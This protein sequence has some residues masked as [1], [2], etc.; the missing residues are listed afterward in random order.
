MLRFVGLFFM[1]SLGLLPE[2]FAFCPKNFGT[3]GAAAP[4]AP[5]P[6]TPMGMKFYFALLSKKGLRL[7]NLDGINTCNFTE[8][9]RR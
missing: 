9:I 8:P 2:F 5:P 4:L 3:G 1:L 6:R 7:L